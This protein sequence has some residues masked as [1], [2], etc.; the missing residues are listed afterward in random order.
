MLILASYPISTR[1]SSNSKQYDTGNST[2]QWSGNLTR[3]NFGIRLVKSS[4]FLLSNPSWIPFGARAG[5]RFSR[6]WEASS[7]HNDWEEGVH[8]PSEQARIANSVPG[9]IG[10]AACLSPSWTSYEVIVCDA[11]LPR[12]TRIRYFRRW[13]RRVM[14]PGEV[15]RFSTRPFPARARRI[16]PGKNLNRSRR[17]VKS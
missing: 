2:R 17:L 7:L 13:P 12:D 11:R 16:I 6:R 1:E 8:C 10:R 3:A 9:G 15:I 14:L 4:T 5:I